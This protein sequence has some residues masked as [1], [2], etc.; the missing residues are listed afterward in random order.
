MDQRELRELEGRCIQD[1]APKCEAACPIHV[2]GRAFA[3]LAAKGDWPAAWKIL[4]K[5]MPFPGVLARI[6]DAPC[7]KA[8]KRG[9]AGDPIEMGAIERVC[10]EMSPTAQ[11]RIH[12]LP[13]KG[14]CVSIV[15]SG[16]SGLTVALDLAKKGYTIRIFEPGPRLGGDLPDQ[17]PE[18]VLEKE[19][20][21]LLSLDVKVHLDADIQSRLFW[22]SRLSESDAVYLGLDGAFA[23][24]WPLDRDKDGQII[25]DPLIRST[26]FEKVFAGGRDPSP[27]WRA[28]PWA[29][30]RHVHGPFHP[31][32]VS[33]RGPG[34]TRAVF[35]PPVHQPGR[36]PAPEPGGPGG[37]GCRL[38]G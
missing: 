5:T 37:W 33:H 35:H 24:T 27:V 1:E 32:G 23:E 6:C 4:A 22:E 28:R 36:G 21:P 18:P 13:S 31:K 10:A 8:C 26:S 3:G 11:I 25:L 29:M 17:S 2:D 12:P 14:K 15:G 34:K 20:A 16:L 19:L 9:E 30:G 7:K 38:Y